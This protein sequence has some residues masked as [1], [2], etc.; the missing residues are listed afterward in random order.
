MLALLTSVIYTIRTMASGFERQNNH[1]PDR[2]T[3]LRIRRFP[4]ML[5]TSE[6]NSVDTLEV[7]HFLKA[8]GAYIGADGQPSAQEAVDYILA[9]PKREAA[10]REELEAAKQSQGTPEGT[11]VVNEAFIDDAVGVLDRA[12]DF[13]D[14]YISGKAI[15]LSVKSLAHLLRRLRQHG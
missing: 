7:E 9:G 1:D 12:G 5:R 8:L 14:E 4:A 3:H 15:A 2:E 11:V 13:V 6:T 10:L